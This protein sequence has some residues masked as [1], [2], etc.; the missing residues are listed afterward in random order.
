MTLLLYLILHLLA[1]TAERC[2]WISA[3]SRIQKARVLLSL[4]PP[5]T[6]CSSHCKLWNNKIDLDFKVPSASS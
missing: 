1:A 2:K 3:G 4:Y 6:Q 5:I